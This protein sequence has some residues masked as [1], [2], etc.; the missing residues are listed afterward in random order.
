[1]D[2]LKILQ[3]N[4]QA[5][6]AAFYN[7]DKADEDKAKRNAVIEEYTDLIAIYKSKYALVQ[8]TKEL[9]NEFAIEALSVLS[10]TIHAINNSNMKGTILHE[11]IKAVLKKG[12]NAPLKIKK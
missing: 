2:F 5:Q 1:M 4:H 7:I 11:E 10:K 12:M 3:E 6:I 8:E 9:V